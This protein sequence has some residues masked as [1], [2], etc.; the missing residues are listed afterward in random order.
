MTISVYASPESIQPEET[1]E[2][3]GTLLSFFDA[4]GLKYTLAENPKSYVTVNGIPLSIHDWSTHELLASVDVK[5]TLIPFGGVFN[6]LGG[7]L[8]GLLGFVFGFL[9]PSHSAGSTRGTVEQGQKIETAAGKANTSKL[10][11]VVP[12]CA[13]TFRRYVDYLTAPRRFFRN[14]REQMLEFHAC[15]GVGHY[16]IDR[17]SVKLADTPFDDL[18]DNAWF[19]IYE[20]DEDLSGISTHENWYTSPEVGGTSSGTAGLELPTL[21]SNRENTQPV[22]YYFGGNYIWRSSESKFPTGWGEGT[23]VNITLALQF[24]VTREKPQ[25]SPERNRFYGDFR[26]LYP[27]AGKDISMV[28]NWGTSR[29]LRVSNSS[30]DSMGYGWIELSSPGKDPSDPDFWVNDI[31][32]GEYTILFQVMPLA[33]WWIQQYSPDSIFVWRLLP[34]GDNDPDWLGFPS[35]TSSSATITFNGGTVYGDWSSEF[36]ATPA[37]ETTSAIEIDFFYPNGLGY[38]SDDAE[39]LTW[40]S[41]IEIQY[42]DA[43]GGPASIARRTYSDGT[44]DQIG[45]TERL[46]VPEMVPAV[47]VRRVGA[48]ATDQQVKDTVQWYGLKVRLPTVTRYPR[49]TTMAVSLRSGGRLAAQSEN[50]INVVT[51]RKLNVLLPDGT[52]STD[53]R[54]T[55]DI[56]AWIWYIA[57]SIGYTQ[58]SINMDELRRLHD[59]W[60]ARGETYS[61]VVDLTTVKQAMNSAFGAGMAQLAIINGE[62]KPVREDVR[63]VAE[64]RFAYSPQN[65]MTPLRRQFNA[66]S[67]DENDGVEIEYFDA[68]TFESK[69][70]IC[71]LPESPGFKLRKVKLNFAA[72]KTFAWRYGMRMARAMKYERWD[73]SFSTEMDAL[74]SSYGGYVA[75]FD[76]LVENGQTAQ[77]RSIKPAPGG[78][79]LRVTE[80]LQWVDGERYVVG[81]RRPDGT[82]AGSW[83]AY[84][85]NNHYS[86][87]ANIPPSSWPSIDLNKELPYIYFARADRFSF[88]ALITGLSPS[89]GGKKVSVK[90]KNYDARI[91]ADDNN[92]PD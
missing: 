74:N 80:K 32:P 27:L 6:A 47:R 4:Q 30:F 3:Q 59:I 65:M 45:F 82:L 11:A 42:R 76:D 18:G 58:D 57:K 37:N 26:H 53:L 89:N 56:S 78:A 39:V 54:P 24:N 84:P 46:N 73:Y 9:M 55:K 10:N 23:L 36:I 16:Q 35:V 79:M 51:Q 52:W 38:I 34:N 86:V 29:N 63:T 41:T 20:P 7:I 71:K 49:W 40:T 33:R 21:E 31:E 77:L 1:Y 19:R 72:D 25:F 75:L 64:Q 87:I 67:H 14:R 70:V 90:A 12:E 44:L 15:V 8:G 43:R 61:Y 5:M 68:E 81:F 17:E 69:T 92:F 50:R 88:P 85:G 91:Y 83:E 22:N 62:I 13:G 60:T 66:K 2:W 28:V 48:Q